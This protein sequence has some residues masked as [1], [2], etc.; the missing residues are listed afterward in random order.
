[1]RPLLLLP[2]QPWPLPHSQP[3]PLRLTCP[4]PRRRVRPL[5]LSRRQHL[6]DPDQ[7]LPLLRPVLNAPGAAPILTHCPTRPQCPFPL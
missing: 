7:A 4:F 2:A 6:P 1:M 5:S 3:L